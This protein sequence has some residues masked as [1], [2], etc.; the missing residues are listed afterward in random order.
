MDPTEPTGRRERHKARTREDLQRAARELFARQ[1]FAATTVQQ[2]ADAADVSERT[3]FRYFASKEDL[4]VL[5][6]VALFAAGERTIRTRP[7]D[8]PPLVS[9][10]ESMIAVIGFAAAARG[11]ASPRAGG[12]LLSPMGIDP[13]DPVVAGRLVRVFVDWEDRLAEV[14]LARFA[15]AA[16]ERPRAELALAA[17]VIARAAASAMRA[18]LRDVREASASAGGEPLG[19]AERLRE[20]FAI[21]AGGCAG[22]VG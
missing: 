9:I 2:I 21:L 22:P 8:E 3:F 17:S 18:T 12:W 16:P 4:L 6:V 20:S 5:D 13:S 7:L 10:L 15:A 19:I 11:A 14:L 1:G